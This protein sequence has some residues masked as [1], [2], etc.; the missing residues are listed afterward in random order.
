MI[1]NRDFDDFKKILENKEKCKILLRPRNWFYK[2]LFFQNPL[3]EIVLWNNMVAI[4]ICSGKYIYNAE[5]VR[6]QTKNQI[7][8]KNSIAGAVLVFC[9]VLLLS[10]C[11][12]GALLVLFWSCSG[13]LLVL[14]W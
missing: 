13:A 10:W 11:C 5:F 6:D 8:I 9:C 3:K 12:S 14:F 1:I 7:K 4:S 2:L